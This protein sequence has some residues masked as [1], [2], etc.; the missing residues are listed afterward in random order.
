MKALLQR[1]YWAEVEVDGRVVGRIARGLLVY[2]GFALGDDEALA[3]DLARKVVEL[4]I[5]EDPDGKLNLSCR[6]VRGGVLAISNFT[7][8]ADTRKGRRPAFTSAAGRE[9]AERLYDIFTDSLARFGC[10][11]ARGVFGARM[12]VRSAAAGPVNVIVEIPPPSP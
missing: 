3:Q 10:G 8:L 6:D 7:L 1:V 9:L 2:V 11:V 4:R 5:F 12:T